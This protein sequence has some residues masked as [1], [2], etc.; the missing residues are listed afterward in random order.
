MA[1]GE[2]TLKFRVM[3]TKS[4]RIIKFGDQQFHMRFTWCSQ[5]SKTTTIG[6]TRPSDCSTVEIPK[7]CATFSA[8]A[9]SVSF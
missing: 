9:L 2:Q 3:T 8:V 5:S 7:V 4:P 1:T 6:V